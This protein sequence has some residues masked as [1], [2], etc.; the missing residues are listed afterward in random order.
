M[1]TLWQDIRYGL[2]LLTKRIGYSAIIIVILALGIGANSAIFSVVN[3]V[4]L[5]PLPYEDAERLVTPWGSK[6]MG[7]QRRTA[8]SYPDF[9]DWRDGTQSFEQLAVYN[10][11]GTLLRNEGGEPEL[12]IGANA[13]VDIFPMLRIKPALGAPSRAKRTS[14]RARQS[15]SSATTSGSAVL[16]PT[17]TS[18]GKL[19]PLELPA[20]QLW[21]ECCRRI[22]DFPLTP[23][24]PIF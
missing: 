10:S 24:R 5:R 20:G 21:S 18:W 7:P 3:A 6:D 22:L 4:L 2:R 17:R 19:S 9:A 12:I 23:R 14:Q 11:S 16:I 13:S 8:V 1:S 15:C